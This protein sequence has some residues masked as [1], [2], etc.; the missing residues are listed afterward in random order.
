MEIKV[1]YEIPAVGNTDSLDKKIIDAMELIGGK[2]FEQGRN[3]KTRT[4]FLRF[5]VA[6]WTT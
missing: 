6:D 2:Y 5:D 1:E 3:M 4:R